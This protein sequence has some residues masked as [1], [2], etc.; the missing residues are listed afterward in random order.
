M[1]VNYK[2]D[3]V[4]DKRKTI[5]LRLLDSDHVLLNIPMAMTRQEVEC[6][7]EAKAGWIARKQA[8]LRQAEDL[9]DQ[10][11]F[12]PAGRVLYLGRWLEFKLSR[13]KIPLDEVKIVVSQNTF[14]IGLHPKA[15]ANIQTLFFSYLRQQANNYLVS[16]VKDIANDILSTAHGIPLQKVRIKEQRSRWGSCSSKGNINLNARILM[17]D[18]SMHY[19]LV[20]HEL[21]HLYHMN[22]SSHFY[23]FLE[24]ICPDH[25]A[26]SKCLRKYDVLL[27]L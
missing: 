10:I 3:I 24:T 9:L 18:Q 19:Y 26:L 25:R 7:L 4:K 14:D 11:V 20:C 1:T 15:P 2:I 22:H 17:L 5:S 12:E 6:F 23:A 8:Q 27:S 16:L 13:I 21:T